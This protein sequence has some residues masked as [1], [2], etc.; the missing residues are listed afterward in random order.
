MTTTTGARGQRLG[1]GIGLAALM[2]SGSVSAVRLPT[3]QE[4]LC[5]SVSIGSEWL[6]GTIRS[7]SSTGLDSV[8]TAGTFVQVLEE[9]R[10]SIGDLRDLS[11]LTASQVARLFGVSRRSINHWL[12]GK[13]MAAQ[14]EERFS[15]LLSTV[16]GLPGASPDE[17]RAVLLDSSSGPSL[18]HQ[19]LAQAPV[20]AVLQV[21]PLDPS[22][23]F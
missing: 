3:R 11:G 17:R 22:E 19:M 14:H 6:P 23:Q 15:L 2:F 4:W 8:L 18:F 1:I 21:N 20:D 16:R 5:P 10:F 12:A 9:P 13:P 7:D